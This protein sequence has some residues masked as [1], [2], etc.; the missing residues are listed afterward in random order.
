MSEPF[1]FITSYFNALCKGTEQARAFLP[2]ITQTADTVAKCLLEGGELYIAAVRPDFPSEGYVRS[3]GLMLLKE[4]KP[5]DTPT[6]KDA[7]LFGWSNTDQDQNLAQQLR[8]TGAYIIGIGPTSPSVSEHTNVHLESNLPCSDICPA[9]FNGATYPLVSLQNLTL[10]WTFTAEL[11]GALTRLGHMPAMFQSVLVPGARERNRQHHGNRFHLEHTVPPLDLSLLGNAYLDAL[12]Q[13]LQTQTHEQPAIEIV[14]HACV[15]TLNNNNR[16]HA[17]LIPH[18]P[19]HQLGAPGDSNWMHR[20]ENTSGETPPSE[21]LAQTLKPGDL[22]FFLGYYRRPGEA[23]KI[24]RQIG[25][26]TVEIIT[27]TDEPEREGP[28]PDFSIHPAWPYQ[29]AL[30]TVPGYDIPILPASGIL[31]SAIYWAV[32]GSM[33]ALLPQPS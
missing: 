31:Q 10:L 21:A 11:V 12:R 7:V 26:R 15:E 18:F 32:I 16:I 33:R 4:L 9:F 2:Q 8:N 1:N 30:V 3:G 14:A 13:I 22:F 20:V 25:A 23:F 19:V 17:F 24:A 6:P 28:S 27:G 5:G 29:D